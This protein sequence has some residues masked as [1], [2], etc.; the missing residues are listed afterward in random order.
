MRESRGRRSSAS[1]SL[2]IKILPC[3]S[4]ETPK[5]HLVTSRKY[6]G[7]RNDVVRPLAVAVYKVNSVR[8]YHVRTL[9]TLPQMRQACIRRRAGKSTFAHPKALLY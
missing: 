5:A 8:N 6:A 1:R 7:E 3:H 9:A 4:V 2:Q